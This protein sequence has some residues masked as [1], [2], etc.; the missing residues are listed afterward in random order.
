MTY[1][2]ASSQA[3]AEAL[4]DRHQR[5]VVSALV[6][7]ASRRFL[8][9]RSESPKTNGDVAGAA[10]KARLRWQFA[11]DQPTAGLVSSQSAALSDFH[12]AGRNSAAS[13]SLTDL[14][15]V[16]PHSHMVGLRRHI[17]EVHDA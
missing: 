13:N 4:F 2:S 8:S 10:F 5:T 6:A 15:F 17:A 1:A 14:A 7:V 9:S 12:A 16:T 3:G 11:F